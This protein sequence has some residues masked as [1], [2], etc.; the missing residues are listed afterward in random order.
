MAG[1]LNIYGIF[2]PTLLIQALVTYLLF[3]FCSPLLEKEQIKKWV[4]MP[5][6]FHF[7]VYVILLGIVALISHLLFV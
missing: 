2:V 5:S 1:E 7:C 3:S 6:L 4:I